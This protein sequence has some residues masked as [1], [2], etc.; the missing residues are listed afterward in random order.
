M[1]AL[2]F[3]NTK[4]EFSEAEQKALKRCDSLKGRK[5]KGLLKTSYKKVNEYRELILKG[6]LIE[7]AQKILSRVKYI[8]IDEI[9]STEYR[10]FVYFMK[11]LEDEFNNISVLESD[12]SA[13]ES[14]EMEEAGINALSKYKE[15]N[16]ID[17]LSNNILEW[18]Q[19]E[20]LPYEVIYTKLLKTK[21]ENEIRENL[22]QIRNRNNKR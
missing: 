12:L 4:Y 9:L 16:V 10:E 6:N 19:I 13:D 20:K 5:A 7:V 15:I 22:I 3:L 11:W 8:S 17:A 21:E 14:D 1:T 2:E 18:E